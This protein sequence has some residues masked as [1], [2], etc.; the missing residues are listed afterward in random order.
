MTMPQYTPAEYDAATIYASFWERLAAL[1]IDG[2]LLWIGTALLGNLLDQKTD[3]TFLGVMFTFK[4]SAM[5][6]MVTWLY[7]AL[8]ESSVYQ[9]TLGKKALGIRVTDY[10][11]GRISF[12]RATGRHFARFISYL[13]LLIGFF[14]MLWD[15]RHRTLHDK[16]AATLVVK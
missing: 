11:G 7:F 3:R 10:A 6:V 14:M 1:L 15:R 4:G 16:I 2:V 8:Q 13:I 12:G 5:R 9:G